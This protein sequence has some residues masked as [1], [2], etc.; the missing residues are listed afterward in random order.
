MD[1][2]DGPPIS[3]QTGWKLGHL[4]LFDDHMISYQTLPQPRDHGDPHTV[5]VL[6]TTQPLSI[7]TKSRFQSL[8]RSSR[9]EVVHRHQRTNFGRRRRKLVRSEG[10]QDDGISVIWGEIQNG[11]GVTSDLA[12]DCEIITVCANGGG[13]RF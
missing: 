10:D 11:Y 4:A 5:A 6:P 2:L 13:Q 3:R 8:A 7:D 1:N 12:S 9:F